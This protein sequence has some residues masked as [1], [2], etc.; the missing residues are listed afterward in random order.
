MLK[1]NDEYGGKGIVL[2]WEV[3]DTEWGEDCVRHS[4]SVHRTERVSLPS[5]PYPSFVDGRLQVADRCSIPRRTSSTAGLST[6][7]SRAC[8]PAAL[9]NVTAVADRQ[10]R[11]CW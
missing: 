5:E 11:H 8:P 2:G 7:V 3:G 9:L 1:P 4:V 6:D 10:C